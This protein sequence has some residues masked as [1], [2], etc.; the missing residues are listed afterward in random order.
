MKLQA[1]S[2]SLIWILNTPRSALV[3]VSFLFMLT[4]WLTMMHHAVIGVC[5]IVALWEPRKPIWEAKHKWKWPHR[6]QQPHTISAL[7]LSGKGKTIQ[8]RTQPTKILPAA[9]CLPQ[10]A[11]VY[12]CTRERVCWRQGSSWLPLSNY[13]TEHPVSKWHSPL[14]IICS[15]RLG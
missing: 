14:W 6:S 2:V 13:D 12:S 11:T 9:N 10:W 5:T 7:K 8:V 1:L 15:Y 3:T 4:C